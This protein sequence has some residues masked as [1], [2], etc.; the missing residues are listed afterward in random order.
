MVETRFAGDRLVG[1]VPVQRLVR[2]RCEIK[3]PIADG[4]PVE[5]ARMLLENGTGPTA[6]VFGPGWLHIR[7]GDC[8]RFARKDEF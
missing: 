4:R 5:T 6:A 2:Q 1:L 7:H 3:N 8:K